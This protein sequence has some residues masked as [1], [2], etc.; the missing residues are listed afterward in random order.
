MIT[1]HKKKCST[2]RIIR[3]MQV[4]ITLSYHLTLVRMAIIKKSANNK[5]QRGCGENLHSFPHCWWE[6][7]L[8]QPLWKTVWRFLRKLKIELSCELAV[9]FLGIYLDK[10]LILKDTGMPTF[11]ATLLTIAKKWKPTRP[12]TNEWIKKIYIYTH[13]CIQYYISNNIHIN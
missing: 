3:E 6:C 11:I 5:C 13:T 4:R 7:K 9:P 1:R 8:V 10:I 2:S 12:L